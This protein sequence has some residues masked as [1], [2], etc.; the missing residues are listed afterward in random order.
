MPVALWPGSM[1][2]PGQD[3][4]RSDGSKMVV[5]AMEKSLCLG[6]GGTMARYSKRHLNEAQRSLFNEREL[7]SL[8]IQFASLVVAWLGC[9]WYVREPVTCSI[10][11][12]VAGVN[13]LCLNDVDVL[14]V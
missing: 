6:P 12:W 8:D 13:I 14:Y 5:K 11:T 9:V 7:E 10:D 2:V 4:K 3:R 1:L